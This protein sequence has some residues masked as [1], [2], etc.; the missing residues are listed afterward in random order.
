MS[1]PLQ[2]SASRARRPHRPL[3][4]S[5]A[6]IVLVLLAA[7]AVAFALTRCASGSGGAAGGAGR[8]PSV[9]VGIAKTVI[10]D[11]PITLSALGTVTPEATVQVTAQV[12]GPLTQVGYRE[13]QLVRRGQLLAQI[14]PRPFQVAVQQA[15]GQ[16][17]RDAA[18]LA[19]ARLDLARYRAL[20]AQNSIA[21][22][23][24]DT[25]AALVRQDE[26]TVASDRAAV[27]SAQLNLTYTHILAPVAGRA[28]L[29]Q[30]DVGNLVTAN[31]ATPITVVTQID[32]VDV[33]FAI[34][35]DS[36][37]AITAHPNFGANLPVTAYDRGG[38]QVL[39]QG[40]LATI[41]N[42]VDTT[43]G[44]VKGKARF[45]NP[46]G[47]LFPNQF[48]NVTVLV[49]TLKNQVMAPTTAIRHG[50][51]GDYVYVLQ[52]GQTVKMTPVKVGP[53]TGE[54]T[55][56]VSGLT[57]GQTVITEGG[58]RLRDGAKVTLPG[59]APQGGAGGGRHRRGSGHGSGGGGGGGGGGG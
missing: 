56:I 15:Q 58:D 28:G 47:A 44:T 54:T 50:P 8:R 3:W 10:A 14:D 42:L 57:A 6:W 43:T 29:R 19:N 13:G 7:A 59:Q 1:Q 30:I 35:E 22:Q 26:G 49:D 24:V 55:S 45:A 23:L 11:V 9:T 16:L 51:Q 37:A 48:V 17:A 38:G 25:Q 18:A 27:A 53:G 41:D 20:L 46:N 32:P 12:S 36:I 21:S 33:V 31:A 4:R 52:P 2:P 39:A 34:P 40:A 5:V